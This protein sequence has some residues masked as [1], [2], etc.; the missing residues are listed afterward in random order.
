MNEHQ[1]L[2]LVTYKDVNLQLKQFN[3]YSERNKVISF[4]SLQK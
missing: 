2:K 3:N 4:S 1:V